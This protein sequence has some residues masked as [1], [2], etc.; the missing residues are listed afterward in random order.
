MLSDADIIRIP[1]QYGGWQIED[2][3]LMQSHWPLVG[4]GS[5][6]VLPGRL[7]GVKNIGPSTIYRDHSE[8]THISS[9]N[10]RLIGYGFSQGRL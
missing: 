1:Q 5:A 7:T 4:E 2:E 8:N 10:N 6:E 9:R 3:L